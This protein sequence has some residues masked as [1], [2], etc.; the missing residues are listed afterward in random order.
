VA[1]QLLAHQPI[2]WRTNKMIVGGSQSA[3]KRTENYCRKELLLLIE[4]GVVE[5]TTISR[6]KS[7]LD[8]KQKVNRIQ[9]NYNKSL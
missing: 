3:Q 4:V 5:R 2:S 1:D 7:L 6:G 8:V 9:Q